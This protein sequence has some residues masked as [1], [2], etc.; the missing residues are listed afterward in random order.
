MKAMPIQ[1]RAKQK[2]ASL[3]SAA[4][5]CFVEEGYENTTAKTIASCA[6]VA[7]GT[8]YQYFENKE[9]IL[10][11]VAQH[12]VEELYQ[13]VPSVKDTLALVNA[14][15]SQGENHLTT[16]TIFLQ[17]LELIYNF[18]AQAPELHQVLEQRKY[19][20]LELAK[21]LDK[22]EALLSE[23]VLLFVQGFNVQQ[24]EVIA[25]N[26]FAMAEG[27][28][29]S[30]VFGKPKKSKQETLVFGAAMLAAYFNNLNFSTDK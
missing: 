23:R 4:Q 20:D 2:R 29:H 22:G 19:L 17:V 15:A 11:V 25:F 14:I 24:P 1:A 13:Q 7:T 28:V 8:F 16:E 21:I 18:H 10:R 26:L 9:D 12:R 5:Q 27:L 6:G 30:H 3:V